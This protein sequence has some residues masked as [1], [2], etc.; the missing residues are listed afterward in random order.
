MATLPPTYSSGCKTD[1]FLQLFFRSGAMGAH[2]ASDSVCWCVVCSAL[3]FIS[4]AACFKVCRH[5]RLYA[6]RTARSC[7]LFPR[8][9]TRSICVWYALQAR[10]LAC[11]LSVGWQVKD[12]CDPKPKRRLQF[13]AI[14]YAAL[15]APLLPDPHFS[16]QRASGGNCEGQRSAVHQAV[17]LRP[18]TSPV[19]Y[20]YVFLALAREPFAS[21]LARDFTQENLNGYQI[22]WEPSPAE[23][24]WRFVSAC[25]HR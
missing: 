10:V 23:L 2:H 25:P 8:G 11:G 12:C 17:A 13:P 15:P 24:P 1:A 4:P 5:F 7:L 16:L 9:S 6:P 19:L 18:P 3:P 14:R 22:H 21:L 20:C